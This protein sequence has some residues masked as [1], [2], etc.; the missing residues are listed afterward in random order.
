MSSGIGTPIGNPIGSKPF[1]FG[2]GGVGLGIGD[3]GTGGSSP[4]L[5]T[6][7]TQNRQFSGAEALSRNR[8]CSRWP[9]VIATETSSICAQLRG[10]TSSSSGEDPIANDFTVIEACIECNGVASPIF[11]GGLRSKTVT[12]ADAE[13]LSDEIV[14]S[15]FGLSTFPVGTT[16][17]F[18]GIIG[19]ASAGMVIP[20]AQVSRGAVS[21]SQAHWWD[22]STSTVSAT[23]VTGPYTVLSGAGFSVRSNGFRP[24]LLGRPLVDGRSFIGSGDSIMEEVSDGT[25]TFQIHGLGFF[26]RS[27]HDGTGN[28]LIPSINISRSGANAA[29]VGPYALELAKYARYAVDE[30]GTNGPLPLATLQSAE[31]ALWTALRGKGVEKIIRTKITPRTTSTDAY[32]TEANQSYLNADYT[33]PSGQYPLFNSWLD[34]KLADATIDNLVEMT[35]VRGADVW[36]WRVNGINTNYVNADQVHPNSTGHEFMATDLRPVLR[37]F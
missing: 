8:Q 30:N 17:W 25:N 16:I 6:V 35:A 20:Y 23:D 34:T 19:V 22:T 28:D 36:K 29:V 13:I 2:S 27:M 32:L 11:F 33:P 26:Q 24:I 4:V 15:A 3:N 12:S 10:A 14:A 21:N 37:T 18:K 9:F 7:V 5:R 1:A 31:I